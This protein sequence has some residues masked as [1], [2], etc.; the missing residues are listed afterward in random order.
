[1]PRG[2]KEEKIFD[3]V[4]AKLQT[5]LTSNQYEAGQNYETNIGNNITAYKDKPLP[6]DARDETIISDPEDEYDDL[7]A[8]EDHHR[9]EK[10][11]EI[12]SYYDGA[13]VED[14]LRK[15]TRDIL[16]CIGAN[17]DFFENKYKDVVFRPKKI[18]RDIVKKDKRIGGIRILIGVSFN[19]EPW[20]MDETSY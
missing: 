6:E 8:Y 7:D 17:R 18:I 12:A 4:V 9:A 3:D 13:N 16:H 1:M 5:I 11:I 2:N 15:R 10:I 20:L 19:T 14:T